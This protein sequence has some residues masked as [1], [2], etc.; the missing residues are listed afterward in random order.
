E[1][2]MNQDEFNFIDSKQLWDSKN[3]TADINFQPVGSND[4]KTFGPIE[5]KGAWK[6][7]PGPNERFHTRTVEVAWPNPAKKDSF[8]CHQYTMGLVGLHIAHKTKNAPQWIWSTFEQV[9]NYSGS[10]PSFTDP[11]CPASKCPPN[12]QPKPPAGGWSGDP[13]IKQSPATQVVVAPGTAAVVLKDAAAVN[14]QV[15]QKL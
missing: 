14:A 13:R 5:V 2:R 6:I 9:D 12:L 11:N 8:L 7:L 15:Q 10:N 1:L 3:Q 4:D